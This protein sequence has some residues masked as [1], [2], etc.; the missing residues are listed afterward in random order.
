MAPQY[1]ARL[2]QRLINAITAPTSEGRLYEVDMRLRPSGKAGPIAV[3]ATTF[4]RYQREEAWVWEQMA[5]TR[6]RVIAGPAELAAEIEATIRSVLTRPR[7]PV[8]LA[9]E[10]AEMR[11]RMAE[12]H[13]PQ[14]IWDAKH[15][16]GGLVDIEFI[17]QY[18]QLRHAHTFPGA[19]AE[20]LEALSRLRAA[21]VLAADIADDLIDALDLGKRCSTASA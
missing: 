5:L 18:L 4:A 13:R 8:A 7:D 21:G 16:R 14:S 3:S 6:A 2:S 12:E 11:A 20:L 10:V 9:V 15:V 1:F 19:I 17:A